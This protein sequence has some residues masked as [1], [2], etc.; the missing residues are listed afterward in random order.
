MRGKAFARSA[1]GFRDQ[2]AL[3]NAQRAIPGA[4]RPFPGLMDIIQRSQ[5]ANGFSQR[6]PSPLELYKD[7]TAL[8]DP[9]TSS[10]H[11]SDCELTPDGL[12]LPDVC[13]TPDTRVV[14]S[15]YYNFWV[16]VEVLARLH[17]PQNDQKDSLYHIPHPEE[18]TSSAEPSQCLSAV[19][20][21][22]LVLTGENR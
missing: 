14:D 16:A 9:F 4:Y 5:T 13:V 17:R 6:A 20:V 1:V 3:L 22:K 7:E 18:S 19:L 10:L 8:H 2:F 11:Q 21:L 12:L 15:G